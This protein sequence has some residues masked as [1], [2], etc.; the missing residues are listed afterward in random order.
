MNRLS[1]LI[2]LLACVASAGAGQ[3]APA[4]LAPVSAAAESPAAQGFKARLTR[5]ESFGRR[6]ENSPAEAAAFDYIETVCAQAGIPAAAS[7]FAESAE[8]YS[9]SRIVEARIGGARPEELAIVVGV[10]SWIDSPDGSDGAAG[11]AF[12]LT[13]L[14]ALAGARGSGRVPPVSL[15]FVFLGAEKRGRM[16]DGE[17]ASL[18]SRTWISREEG[19]RAMAVIYLDFDRYPGTIR[20]RS[21]GSGIL[22][23]YWLY[24]RARRALETAGL[25]L[26]LEA[27]RLMLNRLGL[28]DRYGPI[29]PYLDAGL[30]AIE[31]SG[32]GGGGPPAKGG[33]ADAGAWFSGFMDSFLAASASGFPDEWDRHY[34]AFQIGA[35]TAVVRETSY[36]AFL[37]L[38]SAA[39]A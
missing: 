2:V 16:A 4:D 9:F 22:S 12:A 28:I 30:P 7:G 11:I 25:P 36:V 19:G 21:A 18:G 14:E 15:R 10:D 13:E 5:L 39:A 35:L 6:L 29:R 1:P 20:L 37:V 24:D 8:G 23:P 33:A 32:E 38:F 17:L 34:I 26:S 3:A 27:N 31:L